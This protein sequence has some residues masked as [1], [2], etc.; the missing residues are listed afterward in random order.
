M[1]RVGG[2]LKLNSITLLQ[3]KAIRIISKAHYNAHTTPL[4]LENKILPFDK[5]ITLHRLLF[6]HSIAYKY[7]PPTFNN[8][9]IKNNARNV[10]HN[11][12]NQDYFTLP[13]VQIES[14]RKFPFYALA[15]EW[16]NLGDNIFFY[17][18]FQPTKV[19]PPSSLRWDE[20]S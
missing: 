5:L 7:A 19:H 10:G 13:A 8:S 16:N 9:W 2:G 11:L 17:N 4:F 14:Y 20:S 18:V 6:M 12:R 15:H 1:S 3:K